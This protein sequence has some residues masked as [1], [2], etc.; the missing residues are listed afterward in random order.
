MR[1]V[2][3]HG[4]NDV[5]VDDAPTPQV[6]PHDVLLKIDA[7]GICGS[8]LTFAKHG[9]LREGGAPFPLGHEAAGTVVA[10]GSAVQG[11]E[12]GLRAVINPMGAYD[13]II[14]NGGSEGA[15]ADYLLVRNAKLHSHLLPLPTGMSAERAALVEPLAVALHGVNQ[16]KISADDKVAVFGAGPIGLGAVFWL[17]R[18]GVKNIVSVDLSDA[19]LQ[20][21][22]EL[23]ATATINPSNTDVQAALT[24]LHGASVPV[25]GKPTTATD[26]YIDM[27]GSTV[28]LQAIMSAARF[29]ARLVIT[30]VYPM[31]VS[32]DMQT[33]LIKELSLQMA[34]GYPTE[35]PEVL[36]TLAEV[37]DTDIRAYITH[38]FSFNDFSNAMDTAKL[39]TSGKVMVL[40][41]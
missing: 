31:P 13:N 40:F 8:D 16:G 34:V 1:V 5:R 26:V 32:L 25:L 2:N 19:R 36:S 30:A 29:Q 10:A 22:R 35:L 7:C 37:K 27:A 12:P 6:G 38:R 11:I 17:K 9:F 28:G 15:F 3:I 4:P 39:P 21:A 24:E 18:R 14:G 23:G 41:E 33:M 20:L